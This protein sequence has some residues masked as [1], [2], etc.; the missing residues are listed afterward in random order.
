MDSKQ[1]FKIDPF[2]EINP[3]HKV[4]IINNQNDI[5]TVFKKHIKDKDK[6]YLKYI[7]QLLE[8]R[9]KELM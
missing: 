1:L 6:V 8:N 9:L 3:F 5:Y 2:Y 7:Q 4:I